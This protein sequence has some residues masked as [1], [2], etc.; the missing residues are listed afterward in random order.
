MIKSVANR[1]RTFDKFREEILAKYGDKGELVVQC[2]IKTGRAYGPWFPCG[3]ELVK[4]TQRWD[5]AKVDFVA[6]A[7]TYEL[8]RAAK[9]NQVTK[10]I[11]EAYKVNAVNRSTNQTTEYEIAV[12]I[13]CK[14]CGHYKMFLAYDMSDLE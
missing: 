6:G 12:S 8:R 2:R 1:G 7:V 13:K 11:A 4:A 10:K 9:E 5:A 14:Y 3:E